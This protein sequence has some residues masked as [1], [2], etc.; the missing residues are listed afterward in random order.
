LDQISKD[1]GL[2]RFIP[3]LTWRSAVLTG[4]SARR[5][6][7]L[8]QRGALKPGDFGVFNFGGIIRAL[9]E[10]SF[11][12]WVQY[13]LGTK[14]KMGSYVLLNLYHAYY[15]FDTNRP[16]PQELTYK[17]LTQPALM[18]DVE[19]SRN[20]MADYVW[21]KIGSRLV[22]QH[23]ARAVRLAHFMLEHFGVDGTIF[24]RFNSEPE[25]LLDTICSKY[26]AQL[27]RLAV[28][29]LDRPLDSRAFKVQRWLQRNLSVIPRE[30][31][32]AWI[33]EDVEKRARRVAAF[34]PKTE[35]QPESGSL[36][37]DLLIRYG[38]REDVRRA[39]HSNLQSEGWMGSAVAHYTSKRDRLVALLKQEKNENVRRW[40]NEYI[41]D[42]NSLIEGSKIQ[43]E[44]DDFHNP[45]V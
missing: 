9:D 26:P 1:K 5:I 12:D 32:W 34:A 39:L 38:N 40:L 19:G 20:N 13:F 17:V 18:D 23:P 41:D 10:R 25:R 36:T 7:R 21:A 8:A 15:V 42:V 45:P 16:I 30:H 24:D 43:E 2:Q 14:D 11:K 6:L 37:R 3:E 33:D 22:E 44:R 4:T 31:I 27:W 28:K 29:Y 35:P